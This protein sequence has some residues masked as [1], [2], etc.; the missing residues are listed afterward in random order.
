MPVHDEIGFLL[1]NSLSHSFHH[2]ILNLPGGG[3]GGGR[4]G[5]E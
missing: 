2:E 3:L 4:D 5:F 1:V